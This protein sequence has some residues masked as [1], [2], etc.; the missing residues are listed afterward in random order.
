MLVDY[1]RQYASEH[2]DD[3]HKVNL[4]AQTQNGENTLVIGHGH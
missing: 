3:S 1:T 4:K 2:R